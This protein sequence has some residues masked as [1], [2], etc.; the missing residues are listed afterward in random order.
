MVPVLEPEQ[1]KTALFTGMGKR[2]VFDNGRR[3]WMA[4][5]T[6]ATQSHYTKRTLQIDAAFMSLEEG[7]LL[8]KV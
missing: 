1:V 5:L 7:L 3:G 2:A 8:T 6:P 4:L